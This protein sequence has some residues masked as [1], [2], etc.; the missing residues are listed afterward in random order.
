VI[1][2]AGDPGRPGRLTNTRLI[3]LPFSFS[4][5]LSFPM[6]FSVIWPRLASPRLGG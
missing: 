1:R 5:F 6:H 3:L 4:F 2:R